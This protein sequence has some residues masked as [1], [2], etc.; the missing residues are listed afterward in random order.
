MT[1]TPPAELTGMTAEGLER[2]MLEILARLPEIR[3]T[4]YFA[5]W[6][7]TEE[8]YE[9]DRIRYIADARLFFND[10]LR[11]HLRPDDERHAEMDDDDEVLYRILQLPTV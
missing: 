3:Q 5:E 4:E 9:L 11:D 10:D 1:V 2:R 6:G 7:F 8:M